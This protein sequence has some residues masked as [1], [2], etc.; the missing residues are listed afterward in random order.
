MKRTSA[1]RNPHLQGRVA[2]GGRSPLLKTP[3]AARRAKIGKRNVARL[4]RDQPEFIS[5]SG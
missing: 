1:V 5:P 3:R 4:E 2:E